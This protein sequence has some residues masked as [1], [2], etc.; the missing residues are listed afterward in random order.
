MGG[1]NGDASWWRTERVVGVA[2]GGLVALLLLRF[3]VD[4]LWCLRRMR[5]RVHPNAQLSQPPPAS[6]LRPPAGAD[7]LM[8][9][10]SLSA[11]E[12]AAGPPM[13]QEPI[14]FW[15]GEG[16]AGRSRRAAAKYLRSPTPPWLLYKPEPASVRCKA[17]VRHKVHV[18]P[19]IP[20]PKMP[21][22]PPLPAAPHAPL[23]LRQARLPAAQQAWRTPRG[24]DS[25]SG[26][27]TSGG[28]SSVSLW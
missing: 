25:I 9:S 18:T 14:R 26:G 2:A 6:L 11:S 20:K 4:A 28:A 5:H 17:P 27:S 22:P 13:A 16:L 8:M 21:T 19:S 15:E 23:G 24:A 12:P 10:K 7:R 1:G 3:A